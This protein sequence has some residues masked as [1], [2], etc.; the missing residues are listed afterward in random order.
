MVPIKVVVDMMPRDRG[1]FPGMAIEHLV[2]DM[3]R[4]PFWKPMQSRFFLRTGSP[5]DPPFPCSES[6][7]QTAWD[8]AQTGYGCESAC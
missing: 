8:D 7:P 5:C 3:F 4:T 6:P 1:S 2:R